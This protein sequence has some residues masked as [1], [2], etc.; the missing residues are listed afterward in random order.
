MKHE[1]HAL[2]D[3]V[4]SGTVLARSVIIATL[5]ELRNRDV[6]CLNFTAA[7]SLSY[8]LELTVD[9]VKVL[10]VPLCHIDVFLPTRFRNILF[11]YIQSFPGGM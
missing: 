10:F 6:L 2:C 1:Q 9:D 4:M 3:T 5:K 11:L 7:Y 8:I